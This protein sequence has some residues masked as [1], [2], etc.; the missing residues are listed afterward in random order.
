MAVLFRT[1]GVLIEEK[2]SNELKKNRTSK[3]STIESK[4]SS[5]FFSTVNLFYSLYIA[6][7]LN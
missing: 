3:S 6:L 5:Q 4:M 7:K 2:A 1:N